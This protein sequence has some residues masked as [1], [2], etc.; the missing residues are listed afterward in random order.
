M[1]KIIIME[2]LVDVAIY[3][4]LRIKIGLSK[5]RPIALECV[6]SLLLLWSGTL[7]W[8]NTVDDSPW[9]HEVDK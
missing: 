7:I 4:S 9:I 2:I 5:C 8:I 6:L 1:H 3:S